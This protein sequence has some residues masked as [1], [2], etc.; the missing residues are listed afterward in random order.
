MNIL[1]Y[2]AGIGSP[3]DIGVPNVS[4]DNNTVGQV[5]SATFILIGALAVLFMLVGAARYITSNGE[6]P[7]I[8]Q[9]KNTILYAV[10]GIVVS[11]LGF[12]IVQFV[13][14]TISGTL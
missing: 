2:L 6:Q 11:L 7:R 12:V 8:A 1:A 5:M 13:I 4:A 10:V 3:T 9:A 14:G